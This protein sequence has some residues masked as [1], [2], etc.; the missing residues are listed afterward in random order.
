MPR[1]LRRRRSFDKCGNRFRR[2][3]VKTSS[4]GVEKLRSETVYIA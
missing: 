4:A 2:R 3:V 1:G